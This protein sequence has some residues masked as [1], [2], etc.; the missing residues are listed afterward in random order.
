MTRKR[1]FTRHDITVVYRATN[2]ADPIYYRVQGTMQPPPEFNSI[3]EV[4]EGDWTGQEDKL[5]I[6][7]RDDVIDFKQVKKWFFVKN[8]RTYIIYGQRDFQDFGRDSYK[9]YVGL[10]RTLNDRD[11]PFVQPEWSQIYGAGGFI[12]AV[13]SLE[14]AIDYTL[15]QVIQ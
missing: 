5:E 15:S 13:N 9:K 1:G 8:N 4:P 7:V 10:Y 11:Y 12:D 6:Y 2:V 3:I 14:L